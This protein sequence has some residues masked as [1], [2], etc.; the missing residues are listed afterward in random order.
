MAASGA[1]TSSGAVGGTAAADAVADASAIEGAAA[2]AEAA[3]AGS[4]MT[5]TS[6]TV[7]SADVGMMLEAVPALA[8]ERVVCTDACEFPGE[9]GGSDSGVDGVSDSGN[10]GC[11]TRSSAG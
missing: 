5:D 3:V 2:C 10:D 6:V 7:T 9:F 11:L 4:V 1:D 8:V